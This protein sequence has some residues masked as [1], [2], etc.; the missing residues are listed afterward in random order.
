MARTWPWSQRQVTR[1]QFEHVFVSRHII[2]IKACS[3]DRNTQIFPL[4]VGHSEHELSFSAGRVP[5]LNAAI[6]AR[7]AKALRLDRR[8][9]TGESGRDQALSAPQVL[10]CVYA[11]LHSPGYRERYFEFL[12]SDFP[13]VPLVSNPDLFRDL[14]R[15]GGELVSLHLLES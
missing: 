1:P 5:N 9:R 8:V 14:V 13:R 4:F 3:H 10:N 6:V 7:W 11:I 2:E 15:L 12:R